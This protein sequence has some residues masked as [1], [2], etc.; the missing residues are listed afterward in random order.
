MNRFKGKAIYIDAY[1]SFLKLIESNGIELVG[2]YINANTPAK[3]SINNIKFEM[4]PG[5]ILRTIN[6]IKGF[7]REIEKNGDKFIEVAGLENLGFIFEIQTKEG[8]TIK[9]DF[10]AYKKYLKGK[11]VFEEELKANNHSY[12]GDYLSQKDKVLIDF[13][14][15]H[16]PHETTPDYYLSSKNKKCPVCNKKGN[17]F[18]RESFFEL[19]RKNGHTVIGE[20]K[21]AYEPLLIDFN[22]GHKPHKITP[23]NYKKNVDCPKCQN[24][25]QEQAEERFLKRL[26]ENGHTPKTK[27]KK[28]KAKVLIDFNCGHKPQWVTPSNYNSGKRC[29]ECRE[30]K[31]EKIIKNYLKDNNIEYKT[32]YRLSN[33]K[34][35]DIYL[36]EYNLIVEVN[37]IQHYEEVDFFGNRTLEEERRNDKEKE[38]FAKSLGYNYMIVDYREHIPELALERFLKQFK[39]FLET[40]KEH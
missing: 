40:K 1:K 35:Y 27:Y 21:D 30:S 10:G 25:C 37:G 17:E 6:S 19:V 11:K 32:G 34:F 12:I 36:V 39:Y 14:C 3:F 7:K 26:K 18:G 15:G 24:V 20:Y 38:E 28:L 29:K 8:A 13:N 16:K 31:G 4:R 5:N 33:G 9:K 2:D 22:C 23:H